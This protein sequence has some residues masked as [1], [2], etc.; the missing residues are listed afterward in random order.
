MRLQALSDS[1]DA[2]LALEGEDDELHWRED[3]DQNVW[4]LARLADQPVG[5]AK[6]NRVAEHKDGMHLEAVWVAP[7]ARHQGVGEVLV[8]ALE[9][10]AA[11]L[12]AHLLRLWV[13]A[14]NH[15][16][17]NFYRQLGYTGPTRRQPIK[18]NDRVRF[19]D[20]YEKYLG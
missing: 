6:L 5:L 9:S 11:T 2:F 3:L 19:E 17:K 14:E 18:V 7:Q 12:G 1:P 16:A 8:A 10:I 13:F 20:E 4:C 15:S